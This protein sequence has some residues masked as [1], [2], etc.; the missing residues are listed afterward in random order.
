LEAA[1]TAETQAQARYK[2]GLATIM[3]VADAQRVL[4]QAEIDD[5][6]ARLSVWRSLLSL[7]SA[8]G[9]LTPLLQMAGR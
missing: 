6:L 5:G 4:A 1:R 7:R 8:E 9:D 3:E 2:A